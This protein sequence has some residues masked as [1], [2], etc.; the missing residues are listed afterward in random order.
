MEIRIGQGYDIHRLV[1]E[2]PLILGGVTIPHDKGLLGH[3]DADALCHAIADALLGALAL[4]DI[5][6]FFPPEDPQWAGADSTQLLAATLQQVRS[7]GWELI[8]TDSSIVAERPKLRPHILTMR[9][10]L[11]EVLAVPVDRVSIKA[12]TNEGLDAVGQQ[13]A[14]AVHSVVLLQRET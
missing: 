12:R 2:R 9:T 5:G 8:N 3:S 1:P 11:A 10:R 4:G 13:A 14:I 7:R 6:H